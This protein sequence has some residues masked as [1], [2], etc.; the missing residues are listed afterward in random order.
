[1]ATEISRG[2]DHRGVSPEKRCFHGKNGEFLNIKAANVGSEFQVNG[3]WRSL[4]EDLALA[5][6]HLKS[7]ARSWVL[8]KRV[9]YTWLSK[10]VV[11]G[12]HLCGHRMKSRG[13]LNF[14]DRYRRIFVREER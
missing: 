3:S 13:S 7:C 10:T 5:E 1:M 14:L 9:S 6:W 11:H 8:C 4:R 12:G 2:S